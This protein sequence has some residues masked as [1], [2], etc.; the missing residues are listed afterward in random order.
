M[1]WYADSQYSLTFR[2]RY[3]L[4]RAAAHLRAAAAQVV[5]QRDDSQ[6]VQYGSITVMAGW[7]DV[8]DDRELIREA[9]KEFGEEGEN[10]V[11]ELPDGSV[12]FAGWNGGKGYL[13]PIEEPTFQQRTLTDGA[14]YESFNNGMGLGTA[15]GYAH[16]TMDWIGENHEHWRWR[17]HG[18]GTYSEH[19]GTVVYR[20]DVEP[21]AEDTSVS[22]DDAEGRKCASCKGDISEYA[23]E[24]TLCVWCSG[25]SDD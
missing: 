6:R 10:E 20:G 15:L 24:F 2:T 23:E 16:G 22:E 13:A 14:T 12:T 19:E 9:L 18:D 8:I 5:E 7:V 1:G 17:F 11:H 21:T 3:D 25:E 4:A